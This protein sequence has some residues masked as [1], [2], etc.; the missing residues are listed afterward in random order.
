MHINAGLHRQGKP[1]C[2]VH[3]AQILAGQH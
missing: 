3:I 1:T 2:A